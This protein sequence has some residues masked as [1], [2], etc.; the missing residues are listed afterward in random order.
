MF[1]MPLRYLLLFLIFHEALPYYFYNPLTHSILRLP[2]LQGKKDGYELIPPPRSRIMTRGHNTN[3]YCPESRFRCISPYSKAETFQF[4]CERDSQCPSSYKCCPQKCF[5]HKIC[6]EASFQAEQPN[7][8]YHHPR[9]LIQSSNTLSGN[10]GICEIYNFKCPKP[11]PY[12]STAM[13]RCVNDK[14]CP[15]TFKC[16]QQNCFAHKICSRTIPEST[17]YVEE[18]REKK[19]QEDNESI[20]TERVITVEEEAAEVET[21]QPVE[22]PTKLIT[23]ITRTTTGTT[24]ESEMEITS[25]EETTT[26]LETTTETETTVRLET[27]KPEEE[28]EEEYK[29]EKGDDKD[30][31]EKDDDDNDDDNNDAIDNDDDDDNDDVDNDDVEPN[32]DETNVDEKDYDENDDSEKNE[33]DTVKPLRH[34]ATRKIEIPISISPSDFKAGRTTPDP[35]S[36]IPDYAA[37]YYDYDN[38]TD[39]ENNDDSN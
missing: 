22:L 36:I 10:P 13:F 7:F 9:Q 8:S 24:T 2:S 37:Y 31:D 18:M 20:A 5:Q 38:Q 6:V 32:G 19:E 16:C 3:S 1:N 11:F 12:A 23:S 29:D 15:N 27:I 21:E 17:Q 34:D 28:V 33:D 39:T 14:Q 26:T 30:D 4:E 25:E 35:N